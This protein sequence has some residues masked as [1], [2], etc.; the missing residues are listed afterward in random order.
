MKKRGIFLSIFL[1]FYV[2]IFAQD[3][4]PV[5]SNSSM[6]PNGY[7]VHPS[8]IKK[9][10]TFFITRPLRD[11]PKISPEY[12]QQDYEMDDR[13][14]ENVV[15]RLEDKTK[16]PVREDPVRQKFFGTKSKASINIL[17]NYDGQ[18]SPYYPP[19][20]NGD[21]GPTYYF[22]TVNTTYTIYNKSDGSVAAGPAD[23][24]TIFDSSL[25]GANYNDGDPIVLYDAK[26]GKWF[27]A[28]FSVSG[29]NDY[30]LIAVSKTSD[31][32]G[33]WYSWSFDVDDTP[34]YMK[35]GIWRD[36]Y[37]MATNT[38]NGRDVYV[39]DRSAMLAG[40]P[41]PTMI[42]FDNPWR[43][44]TFDGFHCILPLDNDSTWAP[45]GTPGMF[46]TV[47]DD[48]QGNSADELWLYELHV[49][50]NNP[51]NSTFTRSQTIP[52]A[53]FDG[54]FSGNWDNIA[55]PGTS[56]KLDAVSTVLMFRAQ[57]RNWGS[58]QTIVAAHTVD[59]NGDGSVAG[60]RWY[61]LRNEGSGWYIKQQST[62]SPDNTSRWLPS[63]A[64][65]DHH[66]IAIGFSVSDDNSTYP[67]IRIVGQSSCAPA[68][69]LDMPEI[70]V[71]DGL[72]AQSSYNRWGD[73]AMMSVDPTDGTTF[74]FTTEYIGN[75]GNR[76]TKIVAFQFAED[77][78]PPSITSVSD[79][80]VYEDRGK[81][82]TIDGDG[83]LGAEFYLDNV[84][85]S[86][87]SNSGTQAV[88][89]FPPADYSAGKLLVINSVG[90]DSVYLNI[91]NRN[92]IP[93]VAGAGPT[94]DN[95]PTISSALQGIYGWYGNTAF[96]SGEL[97]GEKTIMV[98]AGTYNDTATTPDITPVST[99]RLVIRN[100][101]GDQVV[102]DGQGKSFV[103]KL[104]KDYISV[105]GLQ[106][107][108]ADK[109][110]IVNSSNDSI[111]FNKFYSAID[112]AAIVLDNASNVFIENNLIIDNFKYGLKAQNSTTNSTLKNNTFANNGGTVNPATGVQLFYDDFEQDPNNNWNESSSDWDWYSGSIFTVSPNHGLGI[113]NSSDYIYSNAID[114]TGYTNLTI[115]AYA[116]SYGTLES[117]DYVKGEYSFDGSNWTQFLYLNDDNTTWTQQSATGVTPSS[118]TLYL[119]FYGN[120]GYN[121]YWLLDDVEVTG[122][123]DFSP[124]D[125]GAAVFVASGS[126]LN[127]KNNILSAKNGTAYYA[128][129]NQ[130]TIT[131]DYN[132]Y[133][134]NG[135]NNLI[136]DGG[137]DYA[138]LSSWSNAGA[139]D[140]EGD[141]LFV[142][143]G[144]YHIQS[145]DGS[146]HNGEWP[147]LTANNGTWTND[148]STSPARDAGDPADPYANE[149][150]SG[151]RINIGAYGNTVQAS[152]TFMCVYPNTQA[153][154]VTVSVASTTSLDVS[155]TR[156]DG[157][158]VIVLAK[159]GSA[160][161]AD[162]VDGTA[163]T[164][165][166]V[167]G[168]GS[169]IGTGNYV[170]YIGTGTNVTVTGLTTGQTYYF[171]V[172]EFTTDNNCYLIP[173]ATASGTP[174]ALTW[175]GSVSTDWQTPQNWTPNQI[176]TA[177]DDINIP[178]GCPN[179][180]V[181]D[182]G[183][184][185]AVCNNMNIENGASVTIA[186]NGRM[187]VNGSITN[188][189]GVSGLIIQSDATGTGSLIHNST[190]GVP[191]TVNLYL[192]ANGGKQWHMLSSPIDAAPFT[193]FPSYTDLY[194]Y[195]ETTDDYWHGNT[196]GPLSTMGWTAPNTAGNMAVNTGYLFNSFDYTMQFQGNLNTPNVANSIS[197]SYTDHTGI[198]N[199]DPT[200]NYD[201]MDGWNL[202]GNPFTS[203]IDWTQVDAHAANLYDA[204]Y[205]YD[206]NAGT[207][208]SYVVGTDSYDGQ[209]TNG[210][211][212]YI[213][214]MQ[215]FFVKGNKSLGLGGT[216]TIPP[217]A[218]VHNSQAFW[219]NNDEQRNMMRLK[220]TA[221]GYSD[222]T[223][224]RVYENATDKFDDNYDAYKLFSMKNGVP[225]IYSL[226]ANH[227][228]YSINTFN[229]QPGT[230]TYVPLNIL[231]F[232]GE[233]QIDVSAFN[234]DNIK[235][236]LL[237]NITSEKLPLYEGR[238]I[239]G[240]YQ[241]LQWPQTRYTL[242]FYKPLSPTDEP[243]IE[244]NEI[245]IYPNPNDGYFNLIVNK[246][247]KHYTV[248]I[249]DLTGKQLYKKEFDNQ[250]IS[251][252][253]LR[254]LKSGSYILR[255][256]NNDE[257]F[258]RY[259]KLI[260][261]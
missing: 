144:D 152:K 162:P 202:I 184:T 257:N 164:A 58:Y 126:S 91:Y 197:I 99:D 156:G 80:H 77:C 167:F 151:N 33:Q 196:Y 218:R 45:P 15:F 40:D 175:N 82:L 68:N 141:P 60:I 214:P 191:A 168:S 79:D 195:D 153:S 210:A 110:L 23:L 22:Q 19:D 183:T 96:N 176:P 124:Y 170:V 85:G 7:L 239:Y 224:L 150:Q 169:Q 54:D 148:A 159:E 64:M 188:N 13:E 57:Y 122:D 217:S 127:I 235:V 43:P 154:N 132:L 1:M 112:S 216:L 101:P 61:E 243:A 12:Y 28:E 51:S 95:H 149:P 116:R 198:G 37:Y 66:Q 219:K 255:V 189:A 209:G 230:L 138:N 72:S 206:G 93:V 113:Y 17:H 241:P 256:Y 16:N 244:V 226:D 139:N 74:W 129:I 20:A 178:A 78:Q 260:V 86:V 120:C 252:L 89:D 114:I 160:V 84:A 211:T 173:G 261:K 98:Y 24:N 62:Y 246:N 131:S 165:N 123:E 253:D 63:I 133:F 136:N 105:K 67:G 231:N 193:V 229:L 143:A 100:N 71:V 233:Y 14:R 201:D 186:P 236:Y 125:E 75:N 102:L 88:V 103:L 237:D 47:V 8:V 174:P 171:A 247:L 248:E 11:A 147:P 107:T 221:N 35:F 81:Q 140:I 39:F 182:D 225:Q 245:S 31:P 48:G 50:W 213:P 134:A 251:Y 172:Y 215:G 10:D 38:S 6:P 205:F 238:T 208:V 142:G 44:S 59:V 222:E 5:S 27:Y 108:N 52:V 185:V 30:M 249:V 259:T 228:E 18:S 137:T 145:V 21:V 41:N 158:Q 203:A 207:Y 212:Q 76:E 180:P 56:Q 65:N 240:V 200:Y 42:G 155:W 194:Y 90:R 130:G 227:T 2:Y 104:T 199:A 190:S 242:L 250:M 29:S 166:S 53:A 119:R 192:A 118:N 70:N 36:G 179:Y 73:Y 4:T 46:I 69:T 204:I 163:Y 115:S 26:A 9:P 55:Q 87:I 234:F 187:T 49:D 117:N 157:D 128:L 161:D 254:Y 232:T 32:T 92:I 146:Y 3:I 220:I 109:L 223:V 34:D 111:L 25:P 97:P 135:N 83:L 258:I 181:V 177:S 121:E 106:F 94:S